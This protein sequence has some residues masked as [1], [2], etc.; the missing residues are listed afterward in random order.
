MTAIKYSTLTVF[1]IISQCAICQTKL[2]F[3]IEAR[4]GYEHNVF[5]PNANKIILRNDVYEKALRSGNFHHLNSGISL[6]VKSKNI[7]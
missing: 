6:K 2:N 5:N 1:R 4:S 3:D 7:I